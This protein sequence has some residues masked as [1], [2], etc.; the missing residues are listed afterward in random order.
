[1]KKLFGTACMNIKWLRSL[2]Y[3]WD[4]FKLSFTCNLIPKL[5]LKK[6]KALKIIVALGSMEFKVKMQKSKTCK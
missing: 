5:I 4:I 1:M 3:A 2:L 6:K